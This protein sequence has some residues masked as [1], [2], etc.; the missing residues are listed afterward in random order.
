MRLSQVDPEERVRDAAVADP[1]ARARDVNAGRIAP[2]IAAAAAVDVEPFDDDVVGSDEDDAAGARPAQE[3]AVAADQM[4]GL[5]DEEIAVVGA[6]G[7]LDRRARRGRVDPCLQARR[8]RRRRT[9]LERA[10]LAVA[11]RVHARRLAV[12]DRHV[13]AFARLNCARFG[14]PGLRDQ[15][16]EREQ[17]RA[18]HVRRARRCGPDRRCARRDRSTTR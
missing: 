12:P 4:H 14:A 11:P 2:E 5:A 1:R 15:E 16:H 6:R 18:N 7:D 10:C 13:P 9:A 17:Q 8:P 3:R